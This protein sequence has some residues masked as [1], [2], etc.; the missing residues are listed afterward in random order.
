MLAAV[1]FLTQVT[2]VIFVRKDVTKLKDI[3]KRAQLSHRI[4]IRQ[5]RLNI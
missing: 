5:Q 1:N 4:G 3:V 2:E